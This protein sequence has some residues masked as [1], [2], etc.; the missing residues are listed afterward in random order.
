[1]MQLVGL[2]GWFGWWLVGLLADEEE[3]WKIKISTRREGVNRSN[4]RVREAVCM[5]I[6]VVM[7]R[8]E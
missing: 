1:M 8:G 7:K 5:C 2:A 3:D 4:V 6:C